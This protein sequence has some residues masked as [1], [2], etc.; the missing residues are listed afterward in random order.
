MCW[1]GKG[2]SLIALENT[3]F[4][5]FTE[6]LVPC[7]WDDCTRRQESSLQSL[8]DKATL[9]IHIYKQLSEGNKKASGI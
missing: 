3:V 8:E 9:F 6:E 4:F 5:F 7:C 2:W 1:R